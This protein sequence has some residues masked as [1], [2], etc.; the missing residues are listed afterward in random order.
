MPKAKK[1]AKKKAREYTTVSL[2][3]QRN[4]TDALA[5][6][7]EYADRTIEDVMVVLIGVA[8]FMGRCTSIAVQSPAPPDAQADAT[9]A[10]LAR[11]R[12]IMEA[13]DPGNAREIFGDPAMT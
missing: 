1:R 3:L 4:Q 6:V 7:A 13:N 10:K 2:Y 11:C 8:M 9:A 12:E 5:Q